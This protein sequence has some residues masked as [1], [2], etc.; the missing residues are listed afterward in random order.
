LAFRLWRIECSVT[1]LREDNQNSL[2]PVLRVVIDSGLL[3][4]FTL[5]SAL[6]CFA[7]ESRAEYLVYD[8]VSLCL[9]V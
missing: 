6:I 1:D 7:T 2:M 9:P 5:I 8:I 4:S 3:Y